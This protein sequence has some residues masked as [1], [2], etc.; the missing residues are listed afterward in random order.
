MNF[1]FCVFNS[2]C[3]FKY[4]G[5]F[6]YVLNIAQYLLTDFRYGVSFAVV[7]VDSSPKLSEIS[8]C[9]CVSCFVV[10]GAD[11]DLFLSSTDVC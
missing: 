10:E 5:Q 7:Y 2:S 8:V 6:F 1:V 4:H 11:G 3:F 9:S